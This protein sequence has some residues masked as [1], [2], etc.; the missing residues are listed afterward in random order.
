VDTL[1]YCPVT[2]ESTALARGEEGFNYKEYKGTPARNGQPTVSRVLTAA[3]KGE[4]V[5][6]ELKTGPGKLTPTGAV[7][8]AGAATVEVNVA[9]KRHEAQRLAAEV[10]AYL[11]AWDVVRMMGQ[12]Q[13][14]G[15][16]PYT[17]VT[18]EEMRNAERGMRNEEEPL[19]TP[20]SALPTSSPR[21]VTRKG[22][23]DGAGK[24]N[25]AARGT[26]GQ[27]AANGAGRMAAPPPPPPPTLVYG[28]GSQVDAANVT[29]VQTFE[30][31]QAE[32][33]VVPASKGALLA[34]YQQ[35]AA[36]AV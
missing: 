16:L 19:R 15:L 22:K 29:E 14:V 12:R 5:Y 3:V 20:H 34:F 35:R 33:R 26:N 25:G 1:L 24:V 2:L 21:P 8:P 31:Y 28:D 32:K 4:Q 17:L 18:V 10:L 9:F 30:L 27:A 6:I 36:T 13:A 11:Q 7:T 23:G